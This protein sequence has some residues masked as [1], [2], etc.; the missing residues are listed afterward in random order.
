MA[1]PLQ[2]LKNDLIYYSARALI[3]ALRWLPY[4]LVSSGGRLFGGL[5]FRL[6][7]GERR[8]TLE[9]LATAFPDRGETER[10][11]MAQAAW[12]NLGRNLFEVAHWTGWGRERILAQVVRA[13]GL[14]NI[15]QALARGRGIFIVTGHLGNWELLGGYL[16]GR[17]KGSAV[18]R[19]LYDPRFDELI[20]RFRVEKMG[21][22]AMIKRGTALR[23]IL[24]AL[25]DNQLILVLCDQDTGRDGVFVPFFGR[26]AWTQSG[27]VRVAQKTG[28]ALVPGFLVRGADGRFELHIEKEIKAPRNGDKEKDAV[29]A[30]RR[31][32]EV[33]EKYVRA[34]PDQWMWMH[35]RWK[36]RPPGETKF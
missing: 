34:Y 24:E 25:R 33:M 31:V 6:A 5:V 18:A 30:T 27:Y 4:P 20:N 11:R 29:E 22:S 7:G 13:E 1:R 32:T 9:S 17:Y 26:P 15:D 28:A 10:A 19:K 21:A 14:E 2:K 12:K 23:G 3:A 16:G 8:K 35:Q 36:T